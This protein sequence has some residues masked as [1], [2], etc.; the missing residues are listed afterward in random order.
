MTICII[1]PVDTFSL[2]FSADA[3]IQV[4]L[5]PNSLFLIRSLHTYERRKMRRSLRRLVAPLG[6]RH[7]L[8]TGRFIRLEPRGSNLWIVGMARAFNLHPRG[9]LSASSVV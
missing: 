4:F 6:R 5:L 7:Q 1:V 9:S 2:S 3:M 8:G